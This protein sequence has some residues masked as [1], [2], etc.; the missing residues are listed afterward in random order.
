MERVEGVTLGERLKHGPMPA[1][2]FVAFF[3]HI[4][5]VVQTAH[6][7]GIVHRDRKPSNIARELREIARVRGAGGR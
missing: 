3:E 4:A 5:A 1:E 7:R 2:Q 6:G